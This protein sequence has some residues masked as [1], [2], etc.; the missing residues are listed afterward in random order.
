MRKIHLGHAWQHH[1]WVLAFALVSGWAGVDWWIRHPSLSWVGLLLLLGALSGLVW[2][3]WRKVHY[4]KVSYLTHDGQWLW[5]ERCYQLTAES[6][7]SLFGF[8]LVYTDAHQTTH[9][10][11]LW[12]TQLHDA[13]ARALA[14]TIQTLRWQR[15][16]LIQRVPV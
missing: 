10:Q 15:G 3:E 6:R 13:D 7:V 16:G 4:P 11:W 9:R 12:A 1:G 2:R 5:S 8:W 14:R